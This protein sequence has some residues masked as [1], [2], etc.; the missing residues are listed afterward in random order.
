MVPPSASRVYAMDEMALPAS[1]FTGASRD[2]FFDRL[3]GGWLR[4]SHRDEAQMPSPDELC[5]V[6]P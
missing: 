3:G 5:L 1:R 4:I 6:G 2:F